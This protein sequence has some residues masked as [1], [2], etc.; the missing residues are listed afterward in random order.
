MIVQCEQC[1]KQFKLNPDLIT[2]PAV[3]VR[4]SNCK[5]VFRVSRPE[6]PEKIDVMKAA[7]ASPEVKSPPPSRRKTSSIRFL[8]LLIPLLLI[9]G[10]IALWLYLPWPLK[11]KPVEK[12]TGIEQLHLVETRGYF[13]ENQ[14]AGQLFVIQG[15]VRNE[16]S[17][18]RRWIHLRAKIYTSDGETARQL[19]FYAGNILSN[20]QLQNMTLDNL[21]AFVQSQPT[22]DDQAQVIGSR[23]EVSFT[24]PFGDLPEVTQLS[25]YSVEILASQ[26]A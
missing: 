12:S 6:K 15:K 4:C 24:V 7:L 5:H 8:L 20:Q 16:F 22:T 1:N 23:Q 17:K 3:R 13:V 26:P 11:P 18:P 2:R 14:K 10:S 25:D 21:L 9:A 19:D